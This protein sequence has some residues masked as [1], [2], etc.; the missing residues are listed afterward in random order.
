MRMKKVKFLFAL[1]VVV[2]FLASCGGRKDRCPS[3]DKGTNS[4][5]KN[6]A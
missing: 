5:V 4:S 1:L 6:I 3:V 2:S